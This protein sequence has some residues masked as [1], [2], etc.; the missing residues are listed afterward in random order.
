MSTGLTPD[1]GDP[2][3]LARL[4]APAADQAAIGLAVSGG[5]DSLALMLLAQRWAR[6]LDTPPRLIVYSLDHGLRPEAASEVQ[7]VLR[8]AE[9][10]GLDAQ[11]LRWTGEKPPTG[12]QEAARQARYRIIGEAMQADGASLLL[13]AHHRADQ[14]E[15]VLMRLAHGS[16]I[17]GL[18]GMTSLSQVENITVFR[19]LLDVEPAS[20][21][22]LVEEAGLTP[23]SDPSNK[24]SA[25]ER[26]RWRKR[27]PQL[28]EDGLDSATLSRFANRMAEADLALTQMADAAFDE[29]VTLDGFGAASL[30]QDAFHALSPAIGRRVLARTLNIVGGRQKPRALGQ[31]EK[32]YDQIAMGDLPRAATLLGAVVRLKGKG[33]TVS[34]E[35]GRALPEPCALGAH[36]KLVWDQRFMITNLSGATGLIAGATD[37]MPRHRL[38]HFLG[39]KVTTPAEAIRTAPLV[40]DAE[41]EILSLGG[42]SFDDRIAVELL[43]D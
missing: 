11:G 22:L 26:V 19:P 17:E 31:I 13:T 33:L 23:V 21:A 38:E 15:T 5:P 2:E 24:D 28:A 9:K 40:R 27:L 42:W 36:Q 39:F 37:F 35:P 16:G 4:F 25:Y 6:A 3:V 30:P 18:K 20:M 32:L 14:A 29:L 43:V 7:M 8:E 34:R 1:L 41:G 10:L 12:L